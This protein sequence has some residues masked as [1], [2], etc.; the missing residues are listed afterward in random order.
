LRP[1]DRGAW[2]QDAGGGARVFAHYADARAD[3]FARLGR[4]CSYCERPIKAGLAVE[5]VYP[6]DKHP[7][8]EREWDNFLLACDN[9]NS[10][11]LNKTVRRPHLLF[12]D[13]HNTFRAFTYRAGGIV[14]PTSGISVLVRRR[15]ERMIRLVGLHKRPNHD[16]RASDLRW[17]DRREAWDK[18]ARYRQLLRQPARD[19]PAMRH[20]LLDVFRGDGHWS[21]WMTIF[22][23]HDDM[24]A[25]LIGAIP[26]TAPDCFDANARPVARPAGVV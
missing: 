17:E 25:L 18:A 16:P 8:R 4:Y 6:K 2:P 1:V 23:D 5:H 20:L 7:K 3:L 24:R 19:T 15:A 14:E 10:T 12:P 9:C 26:G 13:E 11:K 21:V 22:Q